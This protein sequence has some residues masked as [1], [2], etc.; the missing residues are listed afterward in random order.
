[1]VVYTGVE[2]KLMQ[3]L[4]SYKFK[5]SRMQERVR[6]TLACNLCTLILMVFISSLWNGL[7]TKSIYD[8]HWYIFDGTEIGP[9]EITLQTTLSLYIL[10][11]YLIPLDL[12]VILELVAIWYTYYLVSDYHMTHLKPSEKPE[13]A[14]Q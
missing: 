9:T 2:T 1:M 14:I 12:A 10:F 13:D 8:T 4:G 3:N 5:R 6:D 7:K 11:N